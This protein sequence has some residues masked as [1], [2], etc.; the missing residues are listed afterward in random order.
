MNILLTTDNFQQFA[1]AELVTIE[2]VEHFRARGHACTV[3]AWFVG[4]PMKAI[5]QRL[6]IS[7]T[8]EPATLNAFDFNLVWE[9]NQ[10]A[11]VL[12]YELKP[13]SCDQTYFAWRHLSATSNCGVPG[14]VLHNLICDRTYAVSEETKTFLIELGIA[15]DD[16]MLF[17]NPAPDSFH[18]R[19][20][21][22][23]G[24]QLRSIL[25]V[26]NHAPP[27]IKDALKILHSR[28]LKVEHVGQDGSGQRRVTA[29]LLQRWDVVVTIGKTVQYALCSRMPAFVY[30][31]YGGPGYLTAD[32]FAR[33][34]WYNF[35]GRCTHTV[36][37]A[38][39]IA[40][41]LIHGFADARQV[42]DALPH[43]VTEAY[44][45]APYLDELLDAATRAHP[46]AQ[47]MILLQNHRAMLKRESI[48]CAGA[49]NAYRGRN[50][51]K[52]RYEYLKAQAGR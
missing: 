32:N 12:Q 19:A 16:I 23:S 50:A 52:R 44:R 21:R 45:L 14:L 34:A 40:D 31:K 18:R 28:G 15:A 49:G 39:G 11:P 5:A 9:H 13:T 4:P 26:S 33:A 51:F 38:A 48:L 41:A 29:D 22:K 30:D 3:A 8:D 37:D 2:I 36:L 24:D 43:T 42:V 17:P 6:G 35:S 47:R 1:G 20:P 7:V 25:V 27:E 46:N 10:L